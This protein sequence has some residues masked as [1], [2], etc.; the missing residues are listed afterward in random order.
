[1]CVDDFKKFLVKYVGDNP[2]MDQAIENIITDI[3]STSHKHGLSHDLIENLN[4]EINN[5]IN[6]NEAVISH[7]SVEKPKLHDELSSD[8]IQSDKIRRVFSF[9]TF[10]N[11][12]L[13]D[14][15]T[16]QAD[17][18]NLPDNFDLNPESLSGFTGN[19]TGPTWWTWDETNIKPING[20]IYM[21]ELG[22]S[23]NERKNAEN[24]FVVEIAVNKECLKTEFYRST[25]LDAFDEDTL[26]RPNLKPDE[27]FGRTCPIP[28]ADI[29]NKR[30]EIVSKSIRYEEL[31]DD[32]KIEITKYKW[33]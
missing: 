18:Y 27:P 21:H 19:P 16:S 3:R 30:P 2:N 15:F 28:P 9:N 22:I 1:M 17:F 23:E 14:S 33:K 8:D 29:N 25:G 20:S 11:Y 6:L 4:N 13:S 10:K 5:G 24:D 31:D 7:R 32:V 26:F 12:N